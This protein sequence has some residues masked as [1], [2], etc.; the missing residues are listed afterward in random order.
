MKHVSKKILKGGGYLKFLS[1][2]ERGILFLKLKRNYVCVVSI[3][4][5]HYIIQYVI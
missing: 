1:P 2:S 5:L 3:L 4:Y